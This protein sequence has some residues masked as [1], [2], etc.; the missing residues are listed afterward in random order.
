MKY[1]QIKS[2]LFKNNDQGIKQ[3]INKKIQATAFLSSLVLLMLNIIRIYDF[4]IDPNNTGLQLSVTLVLFLLFFSIYLLARLG[5]NNLSAWLLITSYSLPTIFCFYT[6]GADLP[7]ALLMS[8][9]IIM[10]AGI[11]LGAQRAFIVSVVFATSILAIS[12]LQENN[13]W[14]VISDWR[15]E[16]HEFIDAI[17]YV[18]ISSIIFLLAWLTTKENHRALRESERDKIALKEER[19]NLEKKVTI[20]T[21]EILNM[22]RE[23]MEQLQVLA[24]IGRL[25]GGIFHDIINP[26]T[27]VN[28]NLEQMKSDTC[29]S[30]PESQNYIK[31]AL[32]ASDRIKDLVESA[33]NCL[34]QKDSLTIFSAHEE[35]HKIM[36]IMKTKA[37]SNQITL[38]IENIGDANIY[39]SKSKFGQ[40]I[41]NL[42]SNAIDASINS[43]QE[44]IIKIK[45]E[46]IKADKNIKISVIDQGVGISP[47][48][49]EKIFNPFFSTK[50]KNG[51]NIGLGL[52]VVQEIIQQDFK[53]EINVFSQ[54]NKGSVFTI[55]IP[56]NNE[57]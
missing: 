42:V 12:Y 48:N 19:D 24:N 25:S 26:L 55:I 37:K 43:N 23:K 49:I 13:I 22:K 2:L 16:S 31:Q 3:N 18:L 5:K 30:L 52:S 51:K 8:V 47:E 33:N 32:L 54:L 50:I 7:A 53:G 46:K 35:I 6:W 41:M 20:R 28:L 14:P 56:M 1:I 36:Q 27:V 45:I 44:K 4:I 17:T 9:L 34:R 10:M 57:E 11:F 15:L 40:I 38:T 21:K 39:G 29:P